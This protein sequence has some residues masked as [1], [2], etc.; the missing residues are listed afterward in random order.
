MEDQRV[1]SKEEAQILAEKWEIPYHEC[2]AKL[3]NGVDDL[4]YSIVQEI[5]KKRNENTK[6]KKE[7]CFLF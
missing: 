7:N 4:M 2:S 1:V 5:H 3:G 6:Q